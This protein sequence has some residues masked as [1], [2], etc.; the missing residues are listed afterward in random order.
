MYSVGE[1]EMYS[2]EPIVLV[3]NTS[4]IT[5]TGHLCKTFV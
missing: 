3:Y 5:S 1:K 2:C 4:K